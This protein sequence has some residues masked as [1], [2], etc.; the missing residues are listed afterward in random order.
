[1]SK[2]QTQVDPLYMKI[3][4]NLT[5]FGMW[6]DNLSIDESMVPYYGKN[7]MKQFIRGKPIRF[8]FKLW[9]LCSSDGYPYHVDIYRGKDSE[10][11]GPLGERVLSEMVDVLERNSSLN[12][13]HIYFDNFFTSYRLLSTVYCKT[14]VSVQQAPYEKTVQRSATGVNGIQ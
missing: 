12:K 9:A 7:S 3:N 14:K 2:N 10:A 6:H 8:G 5:Q 11:V 13:H 1:M 4:D